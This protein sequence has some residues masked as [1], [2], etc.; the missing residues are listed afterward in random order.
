MPDSLLEETRG[1]AAR[2][3]TSARALVEG[4]RRVVGE[5]KRAVPFRLR[6]ATVRGEGLQPPL[7]GVPGAADPRPRLRGPGGVIALD[8]NLLVHAHREDSPW[9]D[10]ADARVV[11]TP[12]ST[13]PRR[14]WS[15]PSTR[16]THGSSPRASGSRLHGVRELWAADRDFGRFPGLTVRNSLV[17]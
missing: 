6:R 13:G 7:A 1:L 17:G 14:R 11:T 5:R 3:G 10:A 15:P 8:T 12:G 16:W 2:E 9:H 4:L